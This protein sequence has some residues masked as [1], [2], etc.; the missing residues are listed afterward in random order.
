MCREQYS[1]R[2]NPYLQRVHPFPGKGTAMVVRA[3][4]CMA[5]LT[6][7]AVL[8][9]S[10]VVRAG[11]HYDA[12]RDTI[13][14]TD[15]PEQWPCTLARLLTVDAHMGW[16]RVSRDPATGAYT[17]S[18][19]LQI[20][21][22][23]GTETYFRI[24]VKEAAGAET[25]IAK[26]V[27]Y[28]AP[29]WQEGRSRAGLWYGADAEPRVNRLTLG[30]AE[31]PSVRGR[32][33][34]DPPDGEI[35]PLRV[36]RLPGDNGKVRGGQLCV[37]NSTVEGADHTR[38]ASRDV[39]KG[40]RLMLSG[41][42]VVLDGARIQ[43]IP[44]FAGYGLNLLEGQG[45]RYRVRNCIFEN[46]GAG[47]VNGVHDV[48]GCTFRNLHTAI[49][50][51]GAIDATLRECRFEGNT[52]NWDLSYTNRGLTLIDC[53]VAAGVDADVFRSWVSKRTGKKQYPQLTVQRHIV[54]S[55]VD[56]DAR[57]IRD[58]V[59]TV[60]C[61]R[62]GLIPVANN[63]GRTDAAGRTPGRGSTG[64]LLLIARVKQA[65]DTPNEPRVDVF[66]YRIEVAATGHQP[67]TI[68]GFRPTASWQVLEAVLGK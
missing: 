47:I 22:L 9:L 12:A 11:V 36:G 18:A 3:M 27:L 25:L 44:G 57:P 5:G 33:V 8:L 20:G 38:L 45:S 28:V 2:A 31:D 58:A 65:T 53:E 14:V 16:H 15:Y 61:E 59:V 30:A 43:W 56:A 42:A 17:V 68:P 7:A 39:R 49:L 52:I 24:G 64:A 41:E 60:V 35:T 63:H 55:A 29:W 10:G 26:G 40:W 66:S 54:V 48:S 21:A 37:Y 1:Y 62:N 32:L 19:N 51:Y 34:L 13:M 23:D 46:C 6:L 4:Q 50:D 67:C